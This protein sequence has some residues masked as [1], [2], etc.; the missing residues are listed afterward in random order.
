MELLPLHTPGLVLESQI[1]SVLALV[2]VCQ[3][4]VMENISCP[5]CGGKVIK[6]GFS[7]RSGGKKQRYQ[8]KD[9]GFVFVEGK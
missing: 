1:T 7:I 2:L 3:W 5:K 4:I 8:C 9:C 6:S